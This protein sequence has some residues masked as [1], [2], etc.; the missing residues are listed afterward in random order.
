MMNLEVLFHAETL[1][2]NHTLRNIAI[3]HA[4]KTMKSFV[5]PD[6]SSFHVVEF[7][8]NTGAIITR[9]TAQG[10]SDSST[11]SRGQAW[12]LY[13]F[14]NMHKRTSFPR[15]LDTARRMAN[16][17]ISH[18]PSDGIVPWDFNAPTS[19]P[20]PA[21]SSAATIAANGLL[22]LSQEEK[23]LGNLN[24]AKV[25]SDA[26]QKILTDITKLAWKPSWQSLLAN[27]TVNNPMGNSR[28]G[29]VYGDYYFIKAGNKLLSAGLATCP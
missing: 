23:R 13:G 15:Y 12:G 24:E 5:R 6:G 3:S 22:V 8:P 18:I 14:A 2:G 16:Y 4:D 17:F 29:T 1:T 9:R 20:R 7:N 25:W 10:F 21:D 11:W 26:A 27:G 28:T 19:P